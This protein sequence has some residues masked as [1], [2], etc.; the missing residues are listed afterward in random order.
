TLLPEPV[1]GTTCTA[2]RSPGRYRSPKSRRMETSSRTRGRPRPSRPD[3]FASNGGGQSRARYTDQESSRATESRG[4]DVVR[5]PKLDRLSGR[6]R[7]GTLARP[8]V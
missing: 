7:A 6:S 8:V 3:D 2:S 1:G 4:R 5:E